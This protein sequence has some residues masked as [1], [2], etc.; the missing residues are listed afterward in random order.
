MKEQPILIGDIGAT[1]S[2]WA[3]VDRGESARQSSHGFN[4]RTHAPQLLDTALLS[5]GDWVRQAKTVHYYGTGVLTGADRAFIRT[6]FHAI[7]PGISVHAASDLL[8]AARSFG[9]EPAI[10]CILG[11]GSNSC[12]FDGR[13]ITDQIPTLGYPHGDAG[14]GWRIGAELVRR[15]YQRRMPRSLATEFGQLVPREHA[16]FLDDLRN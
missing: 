12:L 1:T 7:N 14:S 3:L 6:A 11:T 8:G 4:P 13:Q 16:T 5:L 2:R 10:V 15:F 9:R